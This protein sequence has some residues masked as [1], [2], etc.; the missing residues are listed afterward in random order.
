VCDALR[1]PTSRYPRRVSTGIRAIPGDRR[2]VF[3]HP[4]R[5][6]V[7]VVGLLVVLNLGVVLL[8]KSDTSPG[9]HGLLPSVVESI[10][11]ERGDLA[12]P[13]DTISVDLRNDLTGVLLIDRFPSPTHEVPE[14]QLAR[15][16]ELGIVSFR[17]SASSDLKVLPAG[18][19]SVTVLYWQRT[20]ARPSRPG[21]F[22]WSFRIAA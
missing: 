21:T 1:S 5:A 14:D 17:P 10:S 11:P 2:R 18:E 16:E 15:V 19:I 7:V 9:S 13:Q 20:K 6:A 3:R 22:S 8:D 12:S 4:G